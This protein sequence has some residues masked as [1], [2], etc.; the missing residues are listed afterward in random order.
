M[1]KK[2]NNQNKNIKKI[3]KFSNNKF[4]YLISFLMAA[5]LINN[6]ASMIAPVIIFEV[7]LAIYVNKRSNYFYKNFIGIIK[8]FLT[9]LISILGITYLITPAGWLRALQILQRSDYCFFQLFQEIG[10]VG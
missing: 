6:K 8:K 9:R 3:F 2:L 10:K 5:L 4:L 7:C 1:K